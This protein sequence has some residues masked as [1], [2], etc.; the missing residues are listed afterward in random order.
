MIK[1]E[2][3]FPFAHTNTGVGT[4][5]A[6]SSEPTGTYLPVQYM[7]QMSDQLLLR[8]TP[9]IRTRHFLVLI[10][11]YRGH[12]NQT[13]QLVGSLFDGAED[14][15]LVSLRLLVGRDEVELF[16][17]CIHA[18]ANSAQPRLASAS[19]WD[20][21]VTSIHSVLSHFYILPPADFDN[22]SSWDMMPLHNDLC[23]PPAPW[24]IVSPNI[25]SGKF[26]YQF[27]KKLYGAR[28]YVGY[29]SL[30]LLDADTSFV[31]P[32]FRMRELFESSGAV[33]AG[34]P[35]TATAFRPRKPTVY[36]MPLDGELKPMFTPCFELLGLRT[37]PF[38]DA[39]S[40]LPLRPWGYHAWVLRR[41]IVHALFNF[42]EKRHNG[43]S[44][45]NISYGILRRGRR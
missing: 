40:G 7:Y 26:R 15:A 5:T 16:E 33:A 20:V 8:R 41:D 6:G 23:S 44:L 35:G 24:G 21:G 22:A 18:I 14:G 38:L 25:C 10:P 9:A 3:K 11:T 4:P 2:T 29:H 39:D 37:S 36:L 43:T 42:V 19:T 34:V 32:S 13:R 1:R 27:I 45:F 17:R 12:I 30:L 28:F 31:A